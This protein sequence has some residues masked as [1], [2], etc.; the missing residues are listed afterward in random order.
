M[1]SYLI[2]AP[3][4]PCYISLQYYRRDKSPLV[5][6]KCP[7]EVKSALKPSIILTKFETIL[8]TDHNIIVILATNA[9]KI[10]TVCN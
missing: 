6:N 9:C 10:L 4:E 1:V 7:E 8:L 3:T 2:N 5:V